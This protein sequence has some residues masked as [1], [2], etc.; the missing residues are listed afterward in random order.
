MNPILEMDRKFV[1]IIMLYV[2]SVIAHKSIYASNSIL[3]FTLICISL[4]MN[5]VVIIVIDMII[6]FVF[7]VN[8]V[9]FIY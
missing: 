2:Q 4:C 9:N 5:L 8:I 3:Y 1:L 7:V 6:V